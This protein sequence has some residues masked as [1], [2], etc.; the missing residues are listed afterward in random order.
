MKP[1]NQKAK[2][3]FFQTNTETLSPL[4][5]VIGV[6]SYAQPIMKSEKFL[7]FVLAVVQ[8][9]DIMDFMIIM[10][11]GSTFMREFDITPQQFSIIVSSYA[12]AAFCS[13][14]IGAGFIDRFDRK[15]VLLFIYAGFT[16]G[17]LACSIAPSFGL[18]LAARSLTGVFGGILAALVLSI[19]GDNIPLERRGAAMGIVMTAFSLASIA[20][21][22]TGLF[23]AAH[24]GW[25][26]PFL[27]IG[28]IA[29][30]LWLLIVFTL[31][32]M[33]KHLESGLVQRNPL[34]VFKN[35]AKDPNQLR[36]LL[37]T[38]ILM[39]GHF[40]VVPFIAPYMELN[41][42]FSTYQIS[43]IYGLGGLF[44]VFLLPYF[45]KLADRYGH[46]QV[47]TIASFFALLSIFAIT[48]L[49]QVSIALALCATS[50]F[51][52]VASGRNVPATTL[53]TS[54]VRPESRGS[55]MSVRASV[56][57]L[58]LGLASFMAG[59]IVTKRPDGSLEH[60][61]YVGYIAI[62]MSLIAILLARKLKPADGG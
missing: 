47:F 61:P 4:P 28:G 40:S 62:A 18:F 8:F 50:S 26:A 14:L 5:D 31:P 43:Y 56:N 20:G 48:N 32:P 23:L 58:A 22:P 15:K 57:E 21:V 45:G 3:H 59:M 34:K 17:T 54:V 13:G 27:T 19:I 16:I 29:A 33:T 24:F 9:T 60:Y 51:F 44:T 42:G 52:I 53:V 10:P 6:L 7:L 46:I 12:I 25:Q 36:A 30:L 41:I 37:F 1:D 49:P 55:F 2:N 38:L 39:L 11:L 35:I